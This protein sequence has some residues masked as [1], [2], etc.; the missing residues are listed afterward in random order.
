M[1]SK[2]IVIFMP[3]I[4]RGG[5]DKN[6][7]IISNFLLKKFKNIT[8]ITASK[9]DKSRFS[10]GV[11][12]ISPKLFIWKKFGRNIKSII[13]LLILIKIFFI[14]KKVLVLSFQ[15]NIWAIILCKIFSQKIITRSNSFPDHW[16]NNFI[17]KFLFKKIYPL[18]NHNI[19]NSLRTK[20]EMK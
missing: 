13:S 17:K 14:K 10:N 6:L 8:I 9:I 20:N 19:V 18:A 12:F 15:S 2:N 3:S 7:Y 5:A 11:K 16:T 1:N 4:E